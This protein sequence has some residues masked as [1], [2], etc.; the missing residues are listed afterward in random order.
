MLDI[1]TQTPCESNIELA[2]QTCVK[3]LVHFKEDNFR[4]EET[5]AQF[6]RERSEEKRML[7]K[8][9]ATVEEQL[10]NFQKQAL[11]RDEEAQLQ[12]LEKESMLV[13]QLQ[14]AEAAAEKAIIESQVRERQVKKLQLKSDEENKKFDDLEHILNKTS[15]EKNDL[16]FESTEL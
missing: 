4:L 1:R 16:Q 6:D 7:T 5:L 12:F 14:S 10:I 3:D 13:K 11:N 8:K 15:K 9:L 2:I